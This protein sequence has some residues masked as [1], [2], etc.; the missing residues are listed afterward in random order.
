MKGSK[1]KKVAPKR[2]GNT[3]TANLGNEYD[4]SLGPFQNSNYQGRG[5]QTE[6]NPDLVTLSNLDDQIL[7]TGGD[8]LGEE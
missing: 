1:A 5:G 8:S 3:L 2:P 4:F 6:N 7:M